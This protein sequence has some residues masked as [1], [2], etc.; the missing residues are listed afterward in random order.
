MQGIY[1]FAVPDTNPAAGNW[2]RTF[3][4]ANDSDEGIGV[5]D[6]DGDGDLDISFT[7]GA[8]SR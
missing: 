5:A 8:T 4:A 1:Y 7:S 3:V 2:P 6:I